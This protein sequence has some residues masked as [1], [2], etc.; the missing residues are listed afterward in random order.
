MS[1][2]LSRPTDSDDDRWYLPRSTDEVR[3]YHRVFTVLLIVLWLVCAA[4]GVY[5]LTTRSFDTLSVLDLVSVL[6]SIITVATLACMG[7]YWL[8]KFAKWLSRTIQ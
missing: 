5:L 7:G 3:W 2:N 8:R 4:N 1:Q 6:M